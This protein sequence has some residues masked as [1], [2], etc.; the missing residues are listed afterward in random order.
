MSE[1]IAFTTVR[2]RCPSCNRTHSTK[3]RARHHMNRCWFN[4]DAAGCK[5]CKHFNEADPGEPEVGAAYVP[6]DCSLHVS[7]T[8]RPECAGCHGEVR[9]WIGDPDSGHSQICPDCQSCPDAVKP[10]PIVHCPLWELSPDFEPSS[11]RS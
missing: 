9:I 2:F 7:L 6:E 8:G 1:P 11:P 3:S 5:T 10:G 4:P